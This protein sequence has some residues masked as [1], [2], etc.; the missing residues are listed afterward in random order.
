MRRHVKPGQFASFGHRS[1]IVPPAVVA[2]PHRIHVGDNVLIHDRAWLSVVESYRG[3]TFEPTLRI[4]DRTV[5]GRDTYISC[6][7]SI[8]IEHD[9]LAG[10]RV[11][12]AD[13]YHDYHDPHTAIAYQ[14]MAEPQPVRICTGVLLN[15][16]VS[17]LPGVT[18]GARSYIGAGAVVTR[19]VPPNSVVVGNPARIVRR[20]DAE[21]EE[22]VD[23]DRSVVGP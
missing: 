4:G 13:S 2:S 8:E 19:D 18:I 10:D 5:L 11:L 7:G 22:W 20:W 17:V 6:I 14:P 1:A 9:V 3:Q 21:R 23:G 15:V 12:I 16:N